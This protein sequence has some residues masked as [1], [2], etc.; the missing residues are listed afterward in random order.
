MSFANSE[1][2]KDNGINETTTDMNA[3]SAS[4]VASNKDIPDTN[5]PMFLKSSL[6][7]AQTAE[8]AR[9]MRAIPSLE[10]EK[11]EMDDFPRRK[12]I[13]SSQRQAIKALYQEI[14][15]DTQDKLIADIRLVL[16]LELGSEATHQQSINFYAAL[17]FKSIADLYDAAEAP[18]EIIEAPTMAS[19]DLN[20][21]Q[22]HWLWTLSRK[23]GSQRNGND[24]S[25]DHLTALDYLTA[26]DTV[27]RDWQCAI[28]E[29]WT[30]WMSGGK[31]GIKVYRAIITDPESTRAGGLRLRWTRAAVER[32]AA[33]AAEIEARAAEVTEARNS[34]QAAQQGQLPSFQNIAPTMQQYGGLQHQQQALQPYQNPPAYQNGFQSRQQAPLRGAIL[35]WYIP[36]SSW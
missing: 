22:L 8:I 2:V 23:M 1:P 4:A 10:C 16:S 3:S 11:A 20:T 34:V 35:S 5:I 28:R 31:K 26:L 17:C 13:A 25:E 29:G 15:D 12:H 24:E 14:F 36:F 21:F 33:E 18:W 6:E 27:A 30:Y 19:A 9:F 32:E 7:Q